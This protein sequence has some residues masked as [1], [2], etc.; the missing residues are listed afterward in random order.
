MLILSTQSNCQFISHRIS[1]FYIESA[2]SK[3]S[4]TKESS[5]LQFQT[6]GCF[7]GE[8]P[9]AEGRFRLGG[10]GAEISLPE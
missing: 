9:S 10:G 7:T 2:F 4:M 8:L 5:G 1:S 3:I 6:P